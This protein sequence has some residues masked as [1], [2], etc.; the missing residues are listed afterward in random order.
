M[1]DLIRDLLQR[2]SDLSTFLHHFTKGTPADAEAALMSILG[3]LCLSA[4]KPWGLARDFDSATISS[5]T[6]TQRVVCFT[7]TPIEHSWMM[8]RDIAGR[9]WDFQPYGVVF[10]KNFARAQGCHPIWYLDEQGPAPSIAAAMRQLIQTYRDARA[11]TP[12]DYPPESMDILRMTPFMELR[13]EQQDFF[14]ER[15]WRHRGDFRFATTDVV[16]VFAPEKDHARLKPLIS[17]LSVDWA[18][19][20]VPLLDPVWGTN[21]IFGAL[22]RARNA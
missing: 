9:S 2:R 15:E 1:A 6:V 20:D 22:S 5:P 7:D 4:R 12:A 11:K 10:A 16:A 19:R 14:W 18:T 13:T 3:G 8:V 17:G 21:Y